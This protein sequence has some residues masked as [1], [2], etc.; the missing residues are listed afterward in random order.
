MAYSKDREAIWHETLSQ[1]EIY[2]SNLAKLSLIKKGINYPT[3]LQIRLEKLFI[4]HNSI[5]KQNFL[6]ELS[7][8][9]LISLVLTAWGVEVRGIAKI[10]EVKEDSVHKF[11]ARV[12]RKLNAKNISNAIH[13]ANLAGLLAFDNIDFL[14]QFP[15]KKNQQSLNSRINIAAEEVETIS[16]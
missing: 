7:K 9:E 3:E 6:G 12:T 2:F 1:E 14:L 15:K 10:I 5:R 8:Q 11:R 16:V 13:R 4:L